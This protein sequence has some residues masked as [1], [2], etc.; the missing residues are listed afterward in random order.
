M[1]VTAASAALHD[2]IQTLQAI[3]RLYDTARHRE[4]SDAEDRKLSALDNRRDGLE[5]QL[6]REVTEK[7]GIDYVVL[8]HAV[9]PSGPIP[10]LKADK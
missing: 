2:L 7:L 6:Q 3:D 9:T 5:A 4:L 10:N 8:W 1:T